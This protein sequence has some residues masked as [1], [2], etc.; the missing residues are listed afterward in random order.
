MESILFACPHCPETFSTYRM[1]T[2]HKDH[3]CAAAP[4]DV[5]NRIDPNIVQPLEDQMESPLIPCPLCQEKFFTF[6]ALNTHIEHTCAFVPTNASNQ[7]AP[8][9]T[10]L[11]SPPEHEAL[12]NSPLGNVFMGV[13]IGGG[14]RTILPYSLTQIPIAALERIGKVFVEG[15]PIYGR[16]NWRKFAGDY[17]MKL[18]TVNHAIA[19]LMKYAQELETHISYPDVDGKICDHLAKVGWAVA[20]LCECERV[21]QMQPD[22]MPNV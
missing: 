21:E 18:E 12:Q 3:L 16:N 1:F 14:R 6:N 5:A 17:A 19:H 20:V 13:G 4:V 10:P 8:N 22:T 7:V 2:L 15:E 9:I 11:T